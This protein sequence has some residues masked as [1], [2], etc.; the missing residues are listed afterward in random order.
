MLH[1]R[2][3]LEPQGDQPDLAAVSINFE[4]SI[5]NYEYCNAGYSLGVARG[6][7]G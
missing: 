4:M 2:L 7:L 5:M 3:S 6:R 1:F